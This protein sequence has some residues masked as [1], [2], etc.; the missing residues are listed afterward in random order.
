[1]WILGSLV[2]FFKLCSA[3]YVCTDT[4]TKIHYDSTRIMHY[5]PSHLSYKKNVCSTNCAPCTKIGKI[6]IGYTAWCSPNKIYQSM[7][8][9]NKTTIKNYYNPLP[10]KY[11]VFENKFRY[12]HPFI[13]HSH[14]CIF[15]TEEEEDVKKVI[16]YQKRYENTK[17]R[18]LPTVLF[19]LPK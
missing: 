13:S 3:Y 7:Y 9:L 14:L 5:Y 11:G 2:I 4:I 16:L 8:N 18:P 6:T 15:E 12:R 1:M 19:Q 10:T 17:H